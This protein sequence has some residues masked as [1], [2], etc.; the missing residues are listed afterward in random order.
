MATFKYINNV[1]NHVLAGGKEFITYDFGIRETIDYP[2]HNGVDLQCGPRGDSDVLAI[3]SGT[4][5]YVNTSCTHNFAKGVDSKGYVNSCCNA[6]GNY[7]KIQHEN[8]YF[9]RYLHLKP[10]TVRVKVGQHVNAGDVLGH[11]GLTGQTSG[12]HLHFDVNNG[13]R[14]IDPLP[15]LQGTANFNALSLSSDIKRGYTVRV[16]AGALFTS[17]VR[18]ASFVYQTEYLVQ[19][20]KNNAALVGVLSGEFIAVGWF[21]IS[22]LYAIS[23]AGDVNTSPE[24]SRPVILCPDAVDYL[25]G[26]SIPGAG[27]IK[28]YYAVQDDENKKLFKIY[29]GLKYKYTVSR[30]KVVGY[31]DNYAYMK[32][33][34]A[35]NARRSP[36]IS[37]V[38]IKTVLNEGEKVLVH[39]VHLESDGRVWD[40]VYV[41]GVWCFVVARHL[42]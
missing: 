27:T 2:S 36:E 35:L 9:T 17:G 18:P 19:Q 15:Y 12:I 40:R 7:V 3:A 32:T 11:M 5:V 4:V 25:T 20:V 6:C 39:K 1:K 34:I 22:D 29:D 21:D 31:A 37:D 30:S 14:Y 42:A 16:K 28:M 33:K 23:K 38:N 26:K 41:D 8:G 10:G 24:N 13:S